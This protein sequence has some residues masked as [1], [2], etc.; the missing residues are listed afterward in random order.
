MGLFRV[1]SNQLVSSHADQVLEYNLDTHRLRS[2]EDPEGRRQEVVDAGNGRVV[3]RR[4]DE[5]GRVALDVCSVGDYVAPLASLT[6]GDRLN[7]WGD[8]TLWRLLPSVTVMPPGIRFPAVAIL[9]RQVGKALLVDLPTIPGLHEADGLPIAAALDENMLAVGITHGGKAVAIAELGPAE[10]L[11]VKK[12]VELPESISTGSRLTRHADNLFL[13]TVSHLVK[14]RV[15]SLALEAVQCLRDTEAMVMAHSVAP[16]GATVVAICYPSGRAILF[17][18]AGLT[19]LGSWEP[20]TAL[21]DVLLLED[22]RLVGQVW[23]K[24]AF[25]EG[26][27]ERRDY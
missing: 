18:T 13:D 2:F 14:L 10:S 16:D 26:R 25:L 15:H 27:I 5:Q 1:S 12:L 3:L 9:R 20:A 4:V 21:S 23:R 7:Y 11:V 8:E 22:D 19:Q 17:S 6:I 24:P